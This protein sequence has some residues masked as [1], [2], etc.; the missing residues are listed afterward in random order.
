V[1][2][3]KEKDADPKMFTKK[4]NAKPA[5]R[6]KGKEPDPQP[7]S[8]YRNLYED[9]EDA[10]DP[11]ESEVLKD[12]V[13]NTDVP[14]PTTSRIPQAGTSWSAGSTNRLAALQ[15]PMTSRIAQAGTSR[16][17]GSTDRSAALQEPTGS[18]IAQAGS[19][20]RSADS[21]DRL[22]ALQEPT[23]SRVPQ[24]SASRSAGSTD[25]SVAAQS[26]P[27]A[28]PEDD[29]AARLKRLKE[30]RRLVGV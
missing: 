23:T 12:A 11:S 25:R 2:S 17:A 19:T 16:S 5:S 7:I 6:K 4:A 3:W 24:A 9:I 10:D 8:Y 27:A 28:V 22:A 1:L 18:R 29:P 15:E 20:S 14:E 21:T 30:A 26:A 13:D